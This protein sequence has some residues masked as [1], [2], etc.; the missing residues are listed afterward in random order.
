MTAAHRSRE[1]DEIIDWLGETIRQTDSSLLDEWGVH[2]APREPTV[3][4]GVA[5]APVRPLS[6]NETALRTMVRKA[7]WRRVAGRPR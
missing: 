6:A 5:A 7:M 1:L 2:D 3:H 4:T